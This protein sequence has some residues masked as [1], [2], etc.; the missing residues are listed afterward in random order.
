MQTLKWLLAL[1]VTDLLLLGGDWSN[2]WRRR[3]DSR[4]E[5]GY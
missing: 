1:R 5:G 4:R 2:F 3:V